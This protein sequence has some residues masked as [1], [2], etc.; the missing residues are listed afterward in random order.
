MQIFDKSCLAEMRS[1]EDHKEYIFECV[2]CGH[3]YQFTMV[4]HEGVD[5]T[6]TDSC[7]DDVATGKH[8]DCYSHG[9]MVL[10]HNAD[11]SW[12]LNER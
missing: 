9:D 2:D 1:Y 7:Y 6:K 11:D 5:Y 8:L 10:V 3:V 4:N 12:E